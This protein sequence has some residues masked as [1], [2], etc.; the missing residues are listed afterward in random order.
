MPLLLMLALNSIGQTTYERAFTYDTN[1]NR[2]SSEIILAKE[3]EK[4]F[5]PSVMDT[6]AGV[7][8][9]IYPN[10][11]NDRVLVETGATENAAAMRAV[12]MTATGAVLEEKMLDGPVVGFDLTGRASGMYYIEIGN[13]AVKQLWKVLKR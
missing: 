1:G 3:G 8:V 6:L 5:R 4:A 13:G 11:T 2:I 10:P 12:L 7:E 9:R